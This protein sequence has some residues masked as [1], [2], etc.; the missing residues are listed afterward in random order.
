MKKIAYVLLM[1]VLVLSCKDAQKE[2]EKETSENAFFET[3]FKDYRELEELSGYEKVSDTSMWDSRNSHDRY[4][5]LQL[6]KGQNS[7]ILF[8]RAGLQH[9]EGDEISYLALD[10]LQVKDVGE[11]EQITIGYCTKQGFPEGEIIALVEESD[12][13]YVKSVIKAW[14]ANKAS[15][16]MEVVEDLDRIDCINEFFESEDATLPLKDFS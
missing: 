11:N 7:L 9:E 12:S 2:V 3:P 10:T 13:L 8:Y 16:K 14:R 5:L 15:E 1:L 6:Q 4:R